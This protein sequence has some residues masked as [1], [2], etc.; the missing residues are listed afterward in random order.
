MAGLDPCHFFWPD[1]GV[2]INKKADQIFDRQFLMGIQLICLWINL[3]GNP[4]FP[5]KQFRAARQWLYPQ[6]QRL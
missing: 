1:H 6:F 5:L 3:K 2:R 4:I